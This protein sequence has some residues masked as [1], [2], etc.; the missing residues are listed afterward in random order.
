MPDQRDKPVAGPSA[1]AGPRRRAGWRDQLRHSRPTQLLLGSGAAAVAIILAT[2]ILLVIAV[3]SWDIRDAERELTT[4][5]I[6]LAEQTAR[7]LQSVDLILESLIEQVQAEQIA[8]AAAYE[9]KNDHA[10][11]ELLKSKTTGVPQ[12][13]AVSL[14]AADGHL[15]NFSRF[16]PIPGVNVADRDYFAALRDDPRAGSFLSFPV[17]NRGTGTWTIYLA[18]RVSGPD[19]KFIGLVLGAINLAYFEDLYEALRLTDGSA[20]RLW[21]SDGT[22]LARYPA[23]RDVGEQYPLPQARQAPVDGKPFTTAS[24]DSPERLVSIKAVRGYPVIVSISRAVSQILADWRWQAASVALAGAACI[25]AVVL[26]VWAL[27]RQFGA[28]EALARV[29]RQRE[30]AV[31]GREKA[32]AQINQLQKMEALGQ[33]TGGIAHDFNNI[34]TVILG[35]ADN[36]R[37]RLPA[38]DRELQGLVAAMVRNGER[39]ATLTHRLLAF[40]RRQPLEPKPLDPNALVAGM[41][42][43]LQRTF[44]AGIV[45]ETVL[46]AETWRI[47]ADANQLESALLNLAVNARDAMPDG[48]MLT[49]ET[50]NATI[51]EAYARQHD[52]V[53]PG[54]YAVVAVSD[55]GTGMA[56]AVMEKVFE[57]FF[58]TKEVGRGTGLGLS[59]VYGFVKQS[60]GHVK[61]YSEVGRGTTVKLYLPRV[62]GDA[63]SDAP[64]RAPQETAAVAPDATILLV[65]DDADVRV[66]TAQVLREIGYRVLEA[67]DGV[68][69]LRLLATHSEIRLLFTDLGLPGALDG[70]HLADQARLHYADLPVLFTTGYARNAVVHHGRLDPDVELIVKPSTYEA[71]AAKL[72]HILGKSEPTTSSQT[73]KASSSSSGSP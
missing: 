7:A 71:L 48:G 45:I 1:Q 21:R 19:G 57:P 58:T 50:A 31:R 37:R 36:L 14:I 72:R 51:G 11:Y 60:G 3:R 64:A 40:A 20:I 56:K 16:F 29:R 65:E 73:G 33:L 28:Y 66:Y 63:A 12:L 41:S 53:R 52:D 39:G 62:D 68:G 4:L 18:R 61:L 43:L 22:L 46:A 27:I 35:N 30:E 9:R 67:E 42:D 32:E 26:F 5:N 49:I 8:T 44:G 70:R 55:T 59:Q 34:L 69:A 6:S 24:S 25:T 2:T 38:E 13:D 10:T 23:I 17:E 47:L 54:Q 15:I